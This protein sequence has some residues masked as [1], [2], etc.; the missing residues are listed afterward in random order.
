MPTKAMGVSNKRCLVE[1]TLS[2]M[3]AKRERSIDY[4]DGRLSPHESRLPITK[5]VTFAS[6]S[7]GSLKVS[8]QLIGSSF[9][10]VDKP[11]MWYSKS[12]RERILQECLEEIDELRLANLDEKSNFVRVVDHCSQSPCQQASDFLESA[13]LEIPASARGMEWGW[14]G[15]V[16]ACIKMKHVQELL[17]VQSQIQGLHP[18]LRDQMLASRSVK[19]SRPGRVLARLLGECDDRNAHRDS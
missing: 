5:N 17:K 13:Q 4:M 3:G 1:S 6:N 19:T 14:A 2:R 15:H 7:D 11:K 12:E 9:S 8:H 16:T 18:T 10:D